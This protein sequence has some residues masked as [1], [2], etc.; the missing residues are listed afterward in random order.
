MINPFQV[1]KD[2]EAALCERTGAKYVVTTTSCTMS[3]LIVC[4]YLRVQ[5]VTI[6]KRTY[7][8]VPQSIIRAGGK[9]QFEDLEWSGIHQLKPYPIW[10]SARR[11]TQNM[12]IPGSYMCLSFHIT[13]VLGLSGGGGAILHDN[14]EAD[15]IL[16]KMRFN[17]RTEGIHPRDDIF[18][19]LGYNCYMYGDDAAEGIR[20]L[21]ILPKVNA[22]LAVSDY[23]DLSLVPLFNGKN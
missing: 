21:A 22:D 23:S 15:P 8:S 7:V 10:D 12:Y 13:K 9:V 2:F 11:L 5:T 4:E 1:V 16:R 20:R 19:V 6:P 17:G 18:N 14:D 3:T